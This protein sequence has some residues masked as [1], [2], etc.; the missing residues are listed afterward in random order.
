MAYV[1]ERSRFTRAF[2]ALDNLEREAASLRN[3]LD[4]SRDLELTSTWFPER[5]GGERRDFIERRRRDRR[6]DEAP[7]RA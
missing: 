5:R 7:E 6:L 2:Q 1:E 4:A 3:A